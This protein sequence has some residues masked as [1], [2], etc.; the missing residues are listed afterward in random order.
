M[1]TAQRRIVTTSLFSIAILFAVLFIGLVLFVFHPIA[2]S[3]PLDVQDI[4]LGLP[5]FGGPPL[6][7]ALVAW[8]VGLYIRAG[9]RAT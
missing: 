7:V 4:V 3:R 2:G 5:V 8:I 1:N 6:L 9:G